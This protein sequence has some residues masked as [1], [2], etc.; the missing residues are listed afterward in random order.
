MQQDDRMHA[1]TTKC[2]QATFST[3]VV[4]VQCDDLHAYMYGASYNQ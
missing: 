2:M 3:A 4:R 1:N